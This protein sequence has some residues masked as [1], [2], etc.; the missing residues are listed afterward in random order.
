M[1]AHRLALACV[2]LL[3]ACGGGGGQE[4]DDRHEE[5][6]AEPQLPAAVLFDGAVE[7]PPVELLS[8]ALEG[9]ARVELGSTTPE[10]GVRTLPPVDAKTSWA[11]RSPGCAIKA[12]TPNDSVVPKAT[13]TEGAAVIC[14]RSP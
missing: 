6:V 1:Q 4:N 3:A 5:G 9:A 2:L 14:G 13:Q 7:G 10:E 12:G 11:S 8:L